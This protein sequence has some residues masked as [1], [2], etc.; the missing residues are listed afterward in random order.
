MDV[1]YRDIGVIVRVTG[2]RWAEIRTAGATTRLDTEVER[3]IVEKGAV[4][5]VRLRGGDVVSAPLVATSLGN[6]ADLT[7][8]ETLAPAER[9]ELARF[10]NASSAVMRR[11]S[12]EHLS[13]R[14]AHTT[15]TSTNARLLKPVSRPRR[16]GESSWMHSVLWNPMVVSARAL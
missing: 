1:M 3:V 2:S 14:A 16:N 9:S 13:T 12:V 11:A 4:Q 10:E 8:R 5:G 7:G 6:G 15:R